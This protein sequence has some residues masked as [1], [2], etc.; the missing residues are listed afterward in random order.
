M[1][2]YLAG[3]LLLALSLAGL[4]ACTVLPD[5]PELPPETAI[6]AG[7]D[8]PIDRGVSIEE[9]RHPGQSA[10]RLV[11]EGQ[12][13]FITRVHTARLAKRSLDVQTYIWH[14]DL[15]GLVMAH[16]IVAAADRGVR[17]R[18]LVD[19]M[20]ARAKTAGLAALDAH[21][22]IEVRLFNPFASRWGKLRLLGEG[23]RDFNRLNHRM[24][25]KTWIADNRV[26]VAGG[27]N[28]GDEYY[29]ASDGVNFVDLD[30]TMVG[31]V[32]RDASASFDRYWNSVQA[33]PVA[34]LDPGAVT[35][36]ALAKLRTVLGE[37]ARQ[38]ETSRY[39][40]ALRSGDALRRLLNG[41]WE[42]TWTS[43]YRFI[44]DEPGKVD[45]PGNDLT[46]SHVATA[47][48]S[49]TGAAR[50]EI[51]LVSPYFVPGTATPQMVA[52]A[53]RGTRVRVLTNSLAASDVGAVHGGYSRYRGELL[54]GGVQIWELK[55]VTDEKAKSGL[56]GSSGASLHTKALVADSK[57]LFVGSY[58]L[59]PRSTFLNCE[60]GVLVE[61]PG[62]AAQLRDIFSLQTD[63]AR[64]W[65]V[66]EE[67]GA[68]SWSDG[69]ETFSSDPQ[70][71]TWR[72]FKAWLVRMLGLDAQL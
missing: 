52:A 37:H 40:D 31:P 64:A 48:L 47:L 46:R 61:H 5:R 53:R 25:N 55:P 15:T 43:H 58:N 36:E 44:S 63:G 26:A 29:T 42:M 9:A 3:R 51:D 39:A 69:K 68:L 67:N 21:P 56:F 18:L 6:P 45:L 30:F 65:R 38:A 16:E 14:A 35:P 20:D 10:F 71:S 62:L 57:V 23:V 33:Y 13:A 59:D 4:T 17:V 66:T 1:P 54:E 60:Q 70:A 11:T 72:R 28:I 32:V 22:N 8:G 24:H 2:R 50:F 34:L 7:H 12:E 49:V 41:D 19:D 27:R